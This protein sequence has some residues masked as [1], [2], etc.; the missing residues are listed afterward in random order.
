MDVGLFCLCPGCLVPWSLLMC[1]CVVFEVGLV[2]ATMV[3]QFV[4]VCSHLKGHDWLMGFL[5]VLR[6]SRMGTTVSE[7]VPMIGPM[8]KNT[9]ARSG[10]PADTG[11]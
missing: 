4:A 9:F 7:C 10:S 6:R 3:A 1:V 8:L 5:R 11:P 2:L